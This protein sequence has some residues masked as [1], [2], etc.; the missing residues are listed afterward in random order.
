MSNHKQYQILAEISKMVVRIYYR[1]VTVNC[2]HIKLHSF[3]V[4][5]QKNC[6]YTVKTS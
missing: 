2:K 3:N 5:Y 6:T 1:N 4:K